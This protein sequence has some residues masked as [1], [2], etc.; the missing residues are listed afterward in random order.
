MTAAL[1]ANMSSS[2][3]KLI[4]RIAAHVIVFFALNIFL[5]QNALKILDSPVN[6]A[7]IFVIN[8]LVVGY[9][10]SKPRQSLRKWEYPAILLP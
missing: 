8:G 2:V 10:L 4:G 7:L 1:L 6:L 3:R 9:S 5:I